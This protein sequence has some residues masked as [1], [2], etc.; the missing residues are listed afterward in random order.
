M[1]TRLEVQPYVYDESRFMTLQV[2]MGRLEI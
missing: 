1:R 2:D